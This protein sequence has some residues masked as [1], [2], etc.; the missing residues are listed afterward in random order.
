MSS[1]RRRFGWAVLVCFGFYLGLPV[2]QAAAQPTAA[3]QSALRS[4]C[5]SDFMSKCSGVK[6]GGAEALQCLQRN[7][8]QLSPGCQTAVNALNPPAAPPQQATSVPAAPAAAPAA[9]APT[10]VR[11]AA[12]AI[13]APAAPTAPSAPAP[14]APRPTRAA[15]AS[16]APAAAPSQPTAQ[17]QAAIR[18]FCQSDFMAT[19]R[20]VQTGGAAAL[21]CLQRN[22]ARLSPNCQ[23]AVAALGGAGPA[24]AAAVAP[25]APAL[26]SAPTPEQQSAIKFTCGRD[27]MANCRGVPQGGPEAL[28]CLQRNAAKLSPNC[29]TSLAAIEDGA[30]ATAAAAAT[31]AAAAPAARPGLPPGPFPLRRAIRERMMNQ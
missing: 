4:N 21:Q 5:R 29:K 10:A 22:S 30:P 27:F 9:P 23:R 3:Q 11:P 28:A 14:A 15:T 19:C 17:Q 6:P 26:A 16:P 7:V 2:V 12:T 20:G 31:P 13:P 25:A 18:Q 24:T 1:H 8:A